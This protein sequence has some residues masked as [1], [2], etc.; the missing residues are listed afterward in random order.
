MKFCCASNAAIKKVKIA[1]KKNQLFSQNIFNKIAIFLKKIQTFRK[2]NVYY[3]ILE[4]L[5][6]I[7]TT[8]L[9]V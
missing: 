6:V 8:Y 4:I 9:P 3:Q 1:R 2:H 7:L 5:P